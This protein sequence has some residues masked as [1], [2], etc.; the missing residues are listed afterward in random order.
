MPH[1]FVPIKK[2]YLKPIVTFPRA[3][4]LRSADR[5]RILRNVSVQKRQQVLNHWRNARLGLTRNMSDF[6][7]KLINEQLL[8]KQDAP[9]KR[10]DVTTNQLRA[11]VST[12]PA[13]QV[14]VPVSKGHKHDTNTITEFGGPGAGYQA[15]L[16]FLNKY[17]QVNRQYAYIV[18]IIDVYSRYAWAIPL[19]TKQSSDVVAGFQSV[20]DQ[21]KNIPKRITTDDGGE[22]K[23]KAFK[24]LIDKH[25][26]ELCHA[27]RGDKDRMGLIERFNR[28]LREKI[29]LLQETRSNG[30]RINH[31]YSHLQPVVDAYNK[32]MHTTLKTT[33]TEVWKEK[34]KNPQTIYRQSMREFEIGDKVRYAIH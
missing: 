3:E 16:V 13:Y 5:T 29:L 15:D 25:K 24:D 21:S 27:Q 11:I 7:R 19:K 6:R 34:K 33:P 17:K 14:T 31:W 32:T 1:R 2:H 18:T 22:F 10:R 30:Q 4:Q 8:P 9:R 20:F 12:D 28:T 23:G 26:I